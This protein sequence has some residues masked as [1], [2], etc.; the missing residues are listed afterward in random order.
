MKT[1][2][3]GSIVLVAGLGLAAASGPALSTE[4]GESAMAAVDRIANGKGSFS[5]G[6]DGVAMFEFNLV[7]NGPPKGSLLCAAEEHH[8]YPGI[9]IRV[10]EIVS[11]RQQQAA[12]SPA[13]D[14]S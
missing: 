7:A 13:V 2:L 3:L 8:S 4:P 5:F 9:I 11:A 10:N 1:F 6:E 14:Q 12:T